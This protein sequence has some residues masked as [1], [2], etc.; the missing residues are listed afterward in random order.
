[1]TTAK[2]TEVGQVLTEKQAIK[3]AH[4]FKELL[5]G[6]FGTGDPKKDAVTAGYLL[7]GYLIAQPNY[8][9][10]RAAQIEQHPRE[11]VEQTLF[12]TFIEEVIETVYED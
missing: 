8:E 6:D 11:N 9:A 1:M 10:Y 4:E 5:E 3:K 12:G 7:L 2:I